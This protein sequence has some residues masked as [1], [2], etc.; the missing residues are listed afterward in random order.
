MA[1]MGLQLPSYFYEETYARVSSNCVW[2]ELGPNVGCL[3]IETCWFR[4]AVIQ[5]GGH[6]SL[7]GLIIVLF[8][9][10]AERMNFRCISVTAPGKI[11]FHGE[12]AVVYGKVGKFL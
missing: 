1:V 2:R 6:L 8:G 7:S 10:A 3:C 4:S 9:F 5:N 12:H 11:I